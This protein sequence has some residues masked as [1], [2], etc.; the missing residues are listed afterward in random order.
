[1]AS[2]IESR[3][4]AE[5][6]GFSVREGADWSKYM[7]YRPIYPVSFFKRI[8]QYHSLKPQAA[9]GTAHDVGAGAGIVS[10]TLVNQFNHV[11]VSDPNDGYTTLARKILVDESGNS[12]AKLR[13]LQEGAEHSSVE[14]GTIDLIAACEMIQWTDTDAAIEEFGRQLKIGG[15]LAVTSY[16]K[17]NIV[18]NE[19]AQKSWQSIFAAYS[20]RTQGLG[21]LYDRAFRTMNTGLENVALPAT[22]WE[23]VKRLYINAHGRLQAFQIDDR[24]SESRVHEGEERLWEEGDPD[25]SDQKGIDWFKAYFATW[26]PRIPEGEIQDLWDGL[27]VALNNESVSIETPIVMIFATRK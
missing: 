26:V 17:P 1:M 13:L 25:W 4:P 2:T 21:D 19:R 8:Y 27:E 7:A 24:S 3:V 16:T 9:W 23:A 5:E 18:G 14:S 20:E 11:V 22:R 10:A 12:E 15:T 6:P